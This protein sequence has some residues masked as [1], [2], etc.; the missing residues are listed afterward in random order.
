MPSDGDGDYCVS[1]ILHIRSV[2]LKSEKKDVFVETQAAITKSSTYPEK[3]VGSE[4]EKTLMTRKE[5]EGFPSQ[6]TCTC[7]YRWRG[8]GG[9]R[10]GTEW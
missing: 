10:T 4:S 2:Y 7:S 8:G 6:N 5:T 3:I 1:F 9:R